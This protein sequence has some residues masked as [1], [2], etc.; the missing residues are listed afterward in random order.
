MIEH[1]KLIELRLVDNCDYQVALYQEDGLLKGLSVSKGGL[2]PFGTFSIHIAQESQEGFWI[3]DWSENEEV[4]QQLL[5]SRLLEF[6]GEEWMYQHC[7]VKKAIPTQQLR[8][9][10]CSQEDLD[11]ISEMARMQRATTIRI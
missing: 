1:P 6:T 9:I 5:D 10:L 4:V 11:E 8:E 3:K 7:S 2:V